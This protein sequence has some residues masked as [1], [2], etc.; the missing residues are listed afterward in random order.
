MSCKRKKTSQ[1]LNKDQ[2]AGLF[3]RRNLQIFDNKQSAFTAEH[4]KTKKEIHITAV[5]G[6]MG[7]A[8]LVHDELQELIKKGVSLTK[9]AVVLANEKLLWPVLK[10]LP[11]EVEHVNITWNIQYVIRKR[12]VLWIFFL[13]FN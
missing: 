5:A 3:L 6:Q 10:L 1:H 8:Q 7:Q 12:T 9:V 11:T 2:E 4:Y 13:I